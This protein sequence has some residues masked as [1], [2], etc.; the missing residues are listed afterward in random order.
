MR[1]QTAQVVARVVIHAWHA[2]ALGGAMFWRGTPRSS[3]VS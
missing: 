2:A 3:S 1:A